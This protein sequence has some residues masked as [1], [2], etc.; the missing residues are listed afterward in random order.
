MKDAY[1]YQDIKDHFDNYINENKEW[2]EENEPNDWKEELH[3]NCFN[4]DYYIIGTYKATQWLG[5]QVFNVID[6]I[7]EYEQDQFGSVMTD[8][9]SPEKVVNMYSYIIGEDI[10]QDYINNLEEVA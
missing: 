1:Q 9:S 2:F 10:V 3:H 7:K 8:F 4:T 6:I 5:D